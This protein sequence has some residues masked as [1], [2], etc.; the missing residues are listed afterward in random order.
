MGHFEERE[1]PGCHGAKDQRVRARL[2]RP[3]TH[4]QDIVITQHDVRRFSWQRP[5]AAGCRI[6]MNRLNISAPDRLIIAGPSACTLTG[7][8]ARHGL[9]P[10]CDQAYLFCRQRGRPPGRISLLNRA[11][12]EADR[13]ARWTEHLELATE[14]SFQKEF[15][16]ASTSR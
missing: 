6:M 5:G 4:Q 11:E 12:E 3:D 13:I 14:E 7:E 10:E 16:K 2:G 1:H 9:L 15:I 8:G